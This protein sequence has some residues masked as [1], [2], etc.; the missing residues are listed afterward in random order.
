MT[1]Q[2]EII[3]RI[4]N[5]QAELGALMLLFAGGELPTEAGEAEAE[6][7]APT[8]APPPEPPRKVRWRYVPGTWYQIVGRN[9]FRNGNNFNLFEYLRETY[10]PYPFSR[11]EL[12]EAIEACKKSGK[13]ESRQDEE[14]YVVVFLRHAGAAKN[15]IEMAEPRDPEVDLDKLTEDELPPEPGD[16]RYQLKGSVPFRRGSIN[17]AIWLRLEETCEGNFSRNELR[18][19]IEGMSQEDE[20]DSKRDLDE[21]TRFF[22]RQIRQKGQVD[23][24]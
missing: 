23:E 5:L 19:M 9:P 8:P 2:A 22:L 17:R 11:E 14:Q 13:I 15:R 1:N 12:S 20:I 3:R 10:G 6:A 18:E 24:L 4:A 7:A 21:L 16:E